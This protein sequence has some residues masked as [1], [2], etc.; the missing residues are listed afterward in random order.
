[1]PPASRCSTCSRAANGAAALAA[2]RLYLVDPLGNLMMSYERDAPVK[3][4][5]DDLK[6]L[7]NL[8]HIG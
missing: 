5:L 7:L 4:L 6:K 1:M 3:G 8:S 2:G